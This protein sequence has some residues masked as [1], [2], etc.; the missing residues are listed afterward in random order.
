MTGLGLRTDPLTGSGEPRSVQLLEIAIDAMDIAS[1]RPFWRAVLGYLPEPGS[2]GPQDAI[3]D[4]DAQL[5][6]IWFQQM[7]EGRPQRNRIHLDISVPHDEAHRRVAATLGAGGVLVSDSAAPAFWCWPTPRARRR[8]SP[9]GRA[10]TARQG[11]PF[12]RSP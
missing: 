6:A 12:G 4:P 2:G 8:A 11:P 5:P 9:P 7:T 1:I 3:V 10:G